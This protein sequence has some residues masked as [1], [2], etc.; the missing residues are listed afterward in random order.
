MAEV[1]SALHAIYFGIAR[2]WF[3]IVLKGMDFRL[4]MIAI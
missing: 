3:D 1:M 2:S 4:F